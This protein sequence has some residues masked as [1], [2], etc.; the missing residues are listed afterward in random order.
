MTSAPVIEMIKKAV[1]PYSNMDESELLQSRRGWF[2]EPRSMTIYLA[3]ILRRDGLKDIGA[4][5]GLRG[6]RSACSIL[7]SMV[8][9]IQK[10]SERRKRFE[11]I[12]R[13]VVISQKE[14]CPLLLLLTY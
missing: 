9:Q 1:C 12:K 5:F 4:E 7:Q 8:K 3:G 6:Y 14:T 11:G 13:R 2:K 10:D